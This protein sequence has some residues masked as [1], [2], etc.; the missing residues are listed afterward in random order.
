[1]GHNEQATTLGFE[2]INSEI[3]AAGSVIEELNQI[4]LSATNQE[5]SP[6]SYQNVTHQ[7]TELSQSYQALQDLLESCKDLV[8]GEN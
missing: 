6:H 3:V 5:K 7:L 8:W 1:M 4:F 2:S